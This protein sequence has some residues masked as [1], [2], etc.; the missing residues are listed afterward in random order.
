MPRLARNTLFNLLG[1]GLP[2][3][4]AVAAIPVLTERAGL[5]R[6][7][8]LA[9]AWALIGYAGF[10][11]LGLSRVFARRIAAA[12]VDGAQALAREAAALG[13]ASR[14]ALLACAGIAL[15]LTFAVP[16]QWLAGEVPAQELRLAWMALLLAL[17]AIVASS[18]QRGA[19]E[20]VE[21]FGA[22]NVL[23]VGMGLW[24]FGGPLVVLFATTAL[25]W[26]V[27][28]L[29]AGRWISLALHWAWCRRLL[30]APATGPVPLGLRA[31]LR[32][33]FWITV[34]NVVAPLMVVFDRLALAA[35]AG[36][37]AVSAYAIAQEVALRLLLIPAA[38]SLALFPRLAALGGA[39]AEHD[40]SA[41]SDAAF[42]WATA[43]MLVISVTSMLVGGPLLTAW[44]A[45]PLAAQTQI[46]LAVMLLGAVANA[47]AQVAFSLLQA[48]GHARAAALLHLAELPLYVT[49]MAWTVPRY[50]LMA[51]AW[52]WTVRTVV[53]AA[54]MIWLAR[55]VRPQSVSVRA[56]VGWLAAIASMA[57][58]LCPEEMGGP[59]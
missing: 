11:D 54:V 55:S 42:R 51:A 27:L 19:M 1:F 53:D 6:F 44:L 37:A 8:F 28:A 47:G 48:T 56:A 40:V 25:P 49:A 13:R 26:L 30:P 52:V 3:L 31:S 24:M 2:L 12:R 57:L 15:V 20:G 36:L 46:L 5:S 50:G 34:S 4:I 17:P 29:T 33:G 45:P 38:L 32:E 21:A 18:L 35:L 14:L 59:S 58:F 9:I 41:L 22:V 16:V 10:L 43:V 7:G 23:R 39:G